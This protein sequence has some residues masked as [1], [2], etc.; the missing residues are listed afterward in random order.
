MTTTGPRTSYSPFGG[1]VLSDVAAKDLATLKDVSEGW[2]IE[3]K[4]Q[5][6]PARSLAKS[7]ASFANHYGGWLFLG[8]QEDPSTFTAGSFPGLPDHEV[9][10]ALESL[11]NASKDLLNPFVFYEPLVLPGPVDAVGLNTGHSILVIRVPQGA[12]CPYVHNDGRIYRRVADSSDPKPETDRAI[13]DLLSER[14]A[15]A[16]AQL[17]EIV[18]RKPSTSKGEESNC[19]IHFNILS[20]PYGI[21]DDLYAG[22]FSE[23]SEAMKQHE[24]PMDNIFPKSGGFIARQVANNDPYNRI[25]TWEFSRRCHSLVTLPVSLNRHQHAEFLT[26]Y[27]SGDAFARMVSEA[28]LAETRVMDLNMVFDACVA[29]ARLH[30]SLVSQSGIRGPFYFKAY[31]ENAWRAVPFID[32]AEFLTHCEAHGLPVVQDTDILAPLGTGLETFVELPERD[33]V[34]PDSTTSDAD[35]RDDAIQLSLPIFRALGIPGELFATSPLEFVTA[36]QRAKEVQQLRN[37][38]PDS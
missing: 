37:S 15:N 21:K 10:D 3:Y 23:F 32:I 33:P 5:I 22:G 1:R 24:L 16:R 27:S 2:F 12:D 13:L 11:R 26:G 8:I 28:G 7:L 6:I 25:F 30:R 18:L 14:S 35:A 34:G 36:G 4:S 19:F 9:S 29:I 31:I 17:K 38:R 20:D